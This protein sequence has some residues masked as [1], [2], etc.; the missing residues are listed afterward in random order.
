MYLPL[1]WSVK[2]GLPNLIKINEITSKNVATL[3][4]TNG[5]ITTNKNKSVNSKITSVEITKKGSTKLILRFLSH[6]LYC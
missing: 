6:Q 3:N 1:I 4:V 5:S 2:S